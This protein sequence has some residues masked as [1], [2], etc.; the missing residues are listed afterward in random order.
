MPRVRRPSTSR[1]SIWIV[2]PAWLASSDKAAPSSP[3]GTCQARRPAGVG[4]S[5]AARSA[6]VAPAV[7]ACAPRAGSAAPL[8]GARV[9]ANAAAAQSARR[10]TGPRREREARG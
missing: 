7:P 4:A 1:A 8:V 3:A 6:A 10:A 9:Q 2:T 5:G